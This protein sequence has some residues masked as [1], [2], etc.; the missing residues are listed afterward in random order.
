VSTGA[1]ITAGDD[2]SILYRSYFT[3]IL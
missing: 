2:F 3:N 1:A